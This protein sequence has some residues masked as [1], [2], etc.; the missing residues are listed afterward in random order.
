ML[1]REYE[2]SSIASMGTEPGQ[3]TG[4]AVMIQHYALRCCLSQLACMAEARH[5]FPPTCVLQCL[6]VR[7]VMQAN[8][9]KL[10]VDD[11]HKEV[12]DTLDYQQ[13]LSKDL[14]TRELLGRLNLSKHI[15]TNADAR[16]A[17]KCLHQLG[18]SDCFHNIFC[19]ENVQELAQK[20]GLISASTP[21]LCKP[22]RQVY[23]IVME[24]IGAQPSET[25][26]IDDSPRNIAAAHELGIFTVL[27]S[28]K[29]GVPHHV[30]GADLVVSHFSQL[31]EMFPDI[32][33]PITNAAIHEE[34]PSI[35][36]I[37]VM[38]S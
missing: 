17:V 22:S 32:F 24:Q 11:W 18:L 6:H 20:A 34:V 3:T 26:F 4:C 9:Y 37:K 25:I 19:F 2:K 1:I 8:G 38:A 21:V 16:H 30:S 5:S 31:P 23:Q 12:H 15:L 28:D 7:L 13:L 29:V 35:V 14:K 27:V 36:P 10:D 33:A